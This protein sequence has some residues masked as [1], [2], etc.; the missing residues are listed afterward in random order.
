MAGRDRRHAVGGIGDLI[1]LPPI[2]ADVVLA[3]LVHGFVVEL[4]GSRRAARIGAILVLINP[5]TWFD[6]AVWGQVDSFGVIFLLLALRDLWRRRPERASLFAV[7]AAVI[8]PQLGILIPILAFVLL[9]RHVWDRLRAA[10]PDGDP[11]LVAGSAAPGAVALEPPAGPSGEPLL[12]RLGQGPIRLVTSAVVGLATAVGLCLPFGLSIVGL[13]Q[14]VVKTAGGYPYITVNAYNPWALLTQDGNGLAANGLWLRDVAGTKAGETATLIAGIPA[15]YVGTGLLLAV[16]VAV[17][18]LVAWRART[19]DLVIDDDLP[20]GPVR[21]ALDDRRLLLVAL[22]ALA[23]AFF[24]LPTRV[25]ERYLFP[26]VILGAILAATSV[27]WRIAYV[28][29]SLASFANLYAIL[30]TP[31]YQNPG[32]K[33]WLGVGDAIRSP[34]GV[35]VIAA[36]HL[37]VFV[38]ALTEL[39][40]RALRRL[41][42]EALVEMHWELADPAEDDELADDPGGAPAPAPVDDVRLDPDRRR[43]GDGWAGMTPGAPA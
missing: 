11:A 2:L 4:G 28:V 10:R 17:G 32:V 42:R 13:L 5:V 38:W 16:I 40:A 3:W 6:S 20:A 8:K 31:F 24:V 18:A 36:I 23:I 43:T 25:H 34:A 7:V 15:V 12:D 27:R 35:T 33:D 39:R 26:F 37:A 19:S 22:T 21:I 14:Q 9:R 1:K 41:D 29:L 30:L